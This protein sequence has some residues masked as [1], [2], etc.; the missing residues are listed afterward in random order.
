MR[1]RSGGG[2][3]GR[4]EAALTGAQVM[5]DFGSGSV[6]LSL[7]RRGDS[8]GLMGW[9]GLVGLVRVSG[10]RKWDWGGR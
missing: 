6:C 8:G 5:F 4:K 10:G 1:E 7:R 2:Q 3:E 9:P